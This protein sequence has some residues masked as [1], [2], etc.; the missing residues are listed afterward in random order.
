M[1]IKG[2]SNSLELNQNSYSNFLEELKDR[3]YSIKDLLNSDLL[4][5][6]ETSSNINRDISQKIGKPYIT[7]GIKKLDK[8]FKMRDVELR[9]RTTLDNIFYKDFE[10]DDLESICIVDDFITTG[11]SFKNAFSLIPKDVKTVGFCLFVLRS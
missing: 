1:A 3:F 5:S 10:K 4:V 2:K 8:K 7:D 9:N 6:I 11:T